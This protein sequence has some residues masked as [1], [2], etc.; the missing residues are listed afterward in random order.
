MVTDSADRP[1]AIVAE[2]RV[3]EVPPERQPWTRISEVARALEPGLILSDSL[4]P[5]QLLAAVRATPASEY[6][7]LHADGSPAGILA[8]SD[9]AAALGGSR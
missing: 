9:L 1:Q 6:L 2:S 3:R 7:V 4:N 8:A 5:G